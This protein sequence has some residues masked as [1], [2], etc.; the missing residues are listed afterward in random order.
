MTRYYCDICALQDLLVEATHH[1]Q[2]LRSMVPYTSDRADLC[3][4]CLAALR[5]QVVVVCLLNDDNEEE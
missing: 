1:V 4:G 5:L 3:P 2:Y